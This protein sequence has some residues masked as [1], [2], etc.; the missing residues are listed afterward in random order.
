MLPIYMHHSDDSGFLSLFQPQEQ[1]PEPRIL[2]VVG[3]W[4][5]LLPLRNILRAVNCCIATD[6]CMHDSLRISQQLR[7]HNPSALKLCS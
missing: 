3:K 4:S 5:V 1:T 2:H 7:G 6:L